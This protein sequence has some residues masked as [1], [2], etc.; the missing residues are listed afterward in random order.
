MLSL[1]RWIGRS[2]QFF[3]LLESSADEARRSSQALREL[4]EAPDHGERLE[5]FIDLRREDKRTREEIS[6]LICN[7]FITPF[8]RED[9]DSL[10]SALSRIPKV[11]KKFAERLILLREHVDVELFRQQAELLQHATGTVYEMVREL[12]H[13]NLKTVRTAHDRLHL[14]E[15]E[16]DTLIVSLLRDLYSGQ[17]EALQAIVLRDLFELLEKVIDRCRDAGNVVFQIVLK[18]S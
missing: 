13:P 7:T 1:Q 6:K 11:L 18:N 14:I 12:R 5:Q 8:E 10:S 9:I 2:D 17:Y 15:A 4:I 3:D 16:A